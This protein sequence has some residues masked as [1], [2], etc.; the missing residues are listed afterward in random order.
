MKKIRRN[1]GISLNSTNKNKNANN[2][3]LEVVRQGVILRD[4]LQCSLELELLLCFG[5]LVKGRGTGVV[6]CGMDGRGGK[7]QCLATTHL[8]QGLFR[9]KKEC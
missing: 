2:L 6:H 9:Y 7:Q 5:F 8:K 3:L 1:I 4:T